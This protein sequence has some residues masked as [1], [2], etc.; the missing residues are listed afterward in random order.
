MPSLI[1]VQ[2]KWFSVTVC[3]TG[4]A[5][6]SPDG[7][8]CREIKFPIRCFAVMILKI[9]HYL[10]QYD[11]A[12]VGWEQRGLFGILQHTTYHGENS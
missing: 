9:C 10:V 4:R 6:R 1:A 3:G 11:L 12:K 5:R 7:V 2:Y 8:G